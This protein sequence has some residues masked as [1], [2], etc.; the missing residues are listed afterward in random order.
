MYILPGAFNNELLSR[1]QR[2]NEDI[3]CTCDSFTTTYRK[4]YKLYMRMRTASTAC[5]NR[6]HRVDVDS[7]H[8][9]PEYVLL[10]T[11]RFDIKS[12]RC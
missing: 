3:S 5:I 1:M 10:N 2:V 7:T 8:Y 6:M 9:V 4:H 12:G 11:V